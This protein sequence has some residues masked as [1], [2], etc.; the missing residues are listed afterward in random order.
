MPTY[1]FRCQTCDTV[2]ERFIRFADLAN[3]PEILC[4]QCAD[5]R[6]QRVWT[7]PIVLTTAARSEPTSVGGCGCGGSCG[8]S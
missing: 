5:R 6:I 1:V 3:S 7:A 8:C 2:F 4:P